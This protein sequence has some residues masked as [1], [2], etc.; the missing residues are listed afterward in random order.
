M[1]E[2]FVDRV[3]IYLK[4]G[5]GGAGVVSFRREKH[6]PR[7]GPDGGNGGQGGSVIL[8]ATARLNALG[9]FRYRKHFA[10]ER[11]GKGGGKHRTGKDG[12]PLVLKVPVGTVV[13]DAVSQDL[14]ADLVQTGA[15]HVVAQGGRGGRG[16]ASFKGATRQAP[17][18]AELGEPGGARWVVLELKLIADVGIVGLPN[19]GKSTLLAAVT[20]A[21]PKIADYPFTTLAPNLGVVETRSGA[22]FVLADIPGMIE[23]AHEGVGLGQQFLRHVERTRVLLH[24]I[25]AAAGTSAD[26]M[27]GYQQIQGELKAYRPDLVRRPQLVVLNKM[28]I[29]TDPGEVD[30]FHRTLLRRRRRVFRISAATGAGCQDLMDATWIELE[31]ALRRARRAPPAPPALVVYRGPDQGPPFEIVHEGGAFVVRGTSVERLVAMTDLTNPESLHRLQ[32][33][34]EGWGLSVA[35]AAR[36]ARGGE[37]VRIRGI[38]FIYDATR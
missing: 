29:V 11:G 22:T 30:A 37:T 24:V 23:G 13:R 18:L 36:G 12:R 9:E 3:K 10:A 6:V 38:E 4:A 2:G 7:G 17:R 19:A 8:E 25:D 28:D 16:N 35:L 1:A 33:K 5:D 34:L 32:R 20:A 21:R 15:R 27:H 26:S 14:I 31:S